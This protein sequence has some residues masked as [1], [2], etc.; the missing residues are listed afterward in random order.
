MIN[1]RERKKKENEQDY[2]FFQDALGS[3]AG[4]HKVSLG[5]IERGYEEGSSNV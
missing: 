1:D 3:F 2:R 4:H 5:V